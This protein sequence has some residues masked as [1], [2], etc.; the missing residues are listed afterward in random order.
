MKDALALAAQTIDSGKAQ[1]QLEQFIKL[2]RE[3]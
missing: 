2:S 1:A 3:S